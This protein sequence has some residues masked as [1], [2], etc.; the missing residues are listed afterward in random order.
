MKLRG[1]EQF[2]GPNSDGLDEA[3]VAVVKPLLWLVRPSP[4]DMN[5]P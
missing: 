4:H 2:S 3:D 5:I 1:G